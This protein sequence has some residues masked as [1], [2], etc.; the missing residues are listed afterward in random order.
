M[1]PQNFSYQLK[2]QFIHFYS[3]PTF[4]FFSTG[5]AGT[6]AEWGE[7]SECDPT[8]FNDKKFRSRQCINA[9]S[10]DA[11]DGD[12]NETAPCSGDSFKA[13]QFLLWTS[14]D[15]PFLKSTVQ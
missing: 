10:A 7:W 15:P 9:P 13:E 11:C 12:P 14:R 1:A 6:W 2:L 4:Y 5:A 3:F 8:W